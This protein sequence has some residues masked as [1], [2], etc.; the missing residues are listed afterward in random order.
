MCCQVN[1]PVL[2]QDKIRILG[3]KDMFDCLEL[4][5]LGKRK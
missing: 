2:L 5:L 1:L 4:C 3:A